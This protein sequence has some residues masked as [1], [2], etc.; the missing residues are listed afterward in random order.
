MERG[1]PVRLSIR[2]FRP[3]GT[4]PVQ[5]DRRGTVG[6]DHTDKT[7]SERRLARQFG[8]SSLA[9]V[10]PECCCERI[11]SRKRS[12]PTRKDTVGSRAV[13]ESRGLSFRLYP[14]IH[15]K[16]GCRRVFG[17]RWHLA[18]LFFSKKI[19]PWAHAPREEMAREAACRYDRASYTTLMA[20]VTRRR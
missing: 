14:P 3:G 1:E 16:N 11:P 12:R 17:A 18:T 10:A 2:I 4:T 7:P 20:R 19:T 8:A 9:L 15:S 13:D 6:L 5:E